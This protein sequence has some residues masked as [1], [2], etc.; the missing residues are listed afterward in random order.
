[1]SQKLSHNLNI[2]MTECH[3]N[4]EELSRRTGIPAS[5]IKKIRVNGSNPT[6]STLAP[7][8]NYFSLSISQIIGDEPIPESRIKGAYKVNTDILQHIPV[9]TWEEAITWPISDD[10]NRQTILSEHAY[11][12]N[13]YTLIVE[14]DDWIN[15]AR[16]TALIVDPALIVDHR[17]FIIIHKYGQKSP[18]LRQA[19]LDEGQIYLK[20]AREGYNISMLTEEHKILGV[21]VEYKKNLK[22]SLSYDEYRQR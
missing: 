21:V 9:I 4:A 19:L 20:P 18:T 12:K 17:D 13:A 15:L 16:N 2:L 6:L 11:S 1:M 8:A 5:T 14:E 7:L 3:L 10:K 22:K